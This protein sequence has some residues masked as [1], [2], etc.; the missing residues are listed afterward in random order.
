MATC[1]VAKLNSVTDI[2][3][4]ITFVQKKEGPDNGGADK[5]SFSR[6]S[7]GDTLFLLFFKLTRRNE[8]E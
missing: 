8:C 5:E 1:I 4:F 6:N 7:H 3:G 2:N